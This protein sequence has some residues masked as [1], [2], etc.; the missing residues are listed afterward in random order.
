MVNNWTVCTT[1]H[2]I[3]QRR[4]VR[5]LRVVWAFLAVV[6]LSLAVCSALF[7]A[8]TWRQTRD[9]S[10]SFKTLQNRL[11][12][13]N[14]QRKAIVQLILE[15]RELLVG[16]RVKRNGMCVSPGRGKGRK[17]ASH[18]EI[19][20][21]SSQQVGDNGVIKGW[22]EG[23]SLNMSGAV[24]YN[25]HSGTFTVLKNGVYFLYCQVLF[26]EHQSQ[27]VK[28]DVVASHGQQVQKLQCVE[29]Y[30]TTPAAGPQLFH[31]LKPCQVSGLLRLE[32][33]TELKAITGS[34]FRLHVVGA[35]AASPHIFSIFKVN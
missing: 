1:M 27:Y 19:T 12:Q 26:N 6:A 9:L 23:E 16:Q 31:F 22:V 3:L 29:G 18:F 10:R 13:V 21:E 8:W 30:G 4:R 34:F 35:S 2:R 32:K 11:E 33:G 28:L 5:K 25:V 7:T 14:S 15:K 20:K 17:G 24:K